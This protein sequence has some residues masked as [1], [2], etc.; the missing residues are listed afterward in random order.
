[1]DRRGEDEAN[2]SCEDFDGRHIGPPAAPKELAAVRDHALLQ[3]GILDLGE[4][5]LKPIEID[6]RGKTLLNKGQHIAKG[7]NHFGTDTTLIAFSFA[8]CVASDFIFSKSLESPEG[9]DIYFSPPLFPQ[10]TN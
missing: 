10:V 2:R 4:S 6:G 1:L 7:G 8:I 3:E 9:D 5:I